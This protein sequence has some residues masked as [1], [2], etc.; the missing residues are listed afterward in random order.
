MA[1]DV[2]GGGLPRLRQLNSRS[3]LRVLRGEPGLTL[4]EISRRTGLSRASTEDVVAELCARGWV[5]E[6]VPTSGKVGRPARRYR[7]RAE[8]GRVLGVEAGARRVVAVVCDLD[9][10]VLESAR[11]A[12]TPAQDH[13][14]RLAAVDE[15]VALALAGAGL[16]GGDIWAT[17]VGTPARA[18]IPDRGEIAGQGEIPGQGEAPDREQIAGRAA[19]AVAGRAGGDLRAHL[20]RTVPGT[21]LVEEDSR[22]AV[23]AECWHGAARYADNVVGLYAGET[24]GLGLMVEGRL[25]HGFGNAAGRLGVLPAFGWS[26]AGERLASWRPK[27]AGGPGGPGPDV[28]G[29]AGS[30]DS[31]AKAAVRRYAGDLGV[32]AAA[33]V[34]TLDP[35]LV[36]LAGRFA[37]AGEVAVEPFR[38]QLERRCLRIPE[39][40]LST[41]GDRAVALGAARLA[42]DHVADL[43]VGGQLASP[44]PVSS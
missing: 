38:R 37:E 15:A 33:L 41:L 20:G 40:R 24:V 32:G 39:I 19:G 4:T 17:G 2:R 29:A 5:T 28:F 7:F 9:G 25:H 10:V 42:L 18:E 3:V 6:A 34:L 43:G 26:R 12:A 31:S 14:A 1:D 22:L 44:P 21:V 23:L 27:T 13:G 11:V 35:Q 8:A 36:L 30:G 16:R